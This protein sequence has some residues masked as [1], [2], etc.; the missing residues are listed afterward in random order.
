MPPRTPASQ[1]KPS[2]DDEYSWEKNRK[3]SVRA[4]ADAHQCVEIML[5]RLQVSDAD[6]SA[7]KADPSLYKHLIAY[8]ME[9]HL[10]IAWYREK[11]K[12]E[13]RKRVAL[14]LAICAL[15][16]LGIGAIP[17]VWRY[18]NEAKDDWNLIF[19]Q[20]TAFPAAA[21]G[22]LRVLSTVTDTRCRMGLFW[23]ARSGLGEI[24]YLFEHKWQGQFSLAR[25]AEFWADID[26]GIAGARQITRDER[27]T[28]FDSL[29]SAS[30][31]LTSAQR[32]VE[33]V[34][35]LFKNPPA[36][37]RFAM[38]AAAASEPPEVAPPKPGN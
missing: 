10:N 7:M 36:A 13:N 17:F 30:D 6:H 37:R 27:Q 33:G 22:I 2:E 25:Q 26:A 28:F 4:A 38:P 31:V 18:G 21:F 3:E 15:A 32:A 34:S 9:V 29:L 12:A 16:V 35:G 5:R 11:M 14:L 1:A 8:G 20:L 24:L 23:R 19:F